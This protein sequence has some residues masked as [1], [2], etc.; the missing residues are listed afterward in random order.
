MAW[1]SRVASVGL[2]LVL[3]AVSSFAVWSSVATS[4]AASRAVAASGLSDDYARAASALN[5]EESLECQYFLDPAARV[6]ASHDE[7]AAVLVAAL[8]EVRRV[9]DANDRAL[10]DRVLVE[11]RAYFAGIDLLF[12]AVDRGDKATMLQADRYQTEPAFAAK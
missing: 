11:H 10:V 6:R 3:L 1:R 5:A 7:A 9:G 4:D 8:G 2:V 12:A